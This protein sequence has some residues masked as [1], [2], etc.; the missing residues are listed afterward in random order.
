M[1]FFF[2]FAFFFFS[3]FLFF[4]KRANHFIF[5]KM[6]SP[7]FYGKVRKNTF[8]L[9]MLGKNFNTQI[10]KYLFS[11]KAEFDISCKLSPQETICM[12]F[13]I[14]LSGKKKQK[15]KNNLSPVEIFTQHAK[16]ENVV[17]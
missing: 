14:L 9:S 15:T 4:D 17:C 5:N 2:V 8:M 11:Q 7:I 13:Q 10:L 3:F 16:R 1:I 6:Q 12:K